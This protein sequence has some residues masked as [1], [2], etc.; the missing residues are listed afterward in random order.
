M[1]FESGESNYEDIDLVPMTP[2]SPSIT[3]EDITPSDDEFW[4]FPRE[5]IEVLKSLGEGNFGFVKK[6]KIRPFHS[7]TFIKDG[8]VAVKM[9]KGTKT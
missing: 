3:F 5:R 2:V 1:A 6:A 8:I 4:Q 9:L 7:M